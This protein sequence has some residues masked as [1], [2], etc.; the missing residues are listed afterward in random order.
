[1]GSGHLWAS[2]K[3]Q[4][5]H[6]WCPRLLSGCRSPCFPHS[7]SYKWESLKELA[8]VMVGQECAWSLPA[9]HFSPLGWYLEKRWRSGSSCPARLFP[10]QGPLHAFYF[11]FTKGWLSSESWES[12]EIPTAPSPISGHL[13]PLETKQWHQRTPIKTNKVWGITP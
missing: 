9:S 4:L 12:P 11:P 5:K 3:H 10:S 6:L 2:W 1:M 13:A 8:V 7:P